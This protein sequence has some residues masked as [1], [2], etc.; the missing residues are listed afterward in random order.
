MDLQERLSLAQAAGPQ[1]SEL[2]SMF[3][4]VITTD[5]ARL[6][7]LRTHESAAVRFATYVN[8]LTNVSVSDLDKEP[9]VRFA[10]IH[11]PTTST[12]V[13]DHIGLNQTS[14]NPIIPET[15]HTHKNASKEF[16]VFRAITDFGR[17]SEDNDD[18]WNY[19]FETIYDEP[20]EVKSSIDLITLE[21]LLYSYILNFIPAPYADN[22]FWDYCYEEV[23]P[24]NFK[25]NLDLFGKLPAIPGSL[26]D[27]CGTIVGAR[28]QA[29][30]LTNDLSLMKSLMWDKEL[31]STGI[32]GLYWQDTRSP[33][34]SVASNSD[35][36]P[37]MLRELFEEESKDEEGLAD[38]Q[39]PVIWRLSCN[40]KSPLDVLEGIVSLIESSSISDEDALL[41]G[42][43]SD[44][45]Y[46]LI[47]NPSV[48]GA[49]RNRVE[50][51][52]IERF[53]DPADYE[54]AED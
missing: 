24:K 47:T 36:T 16:Q 37:E 38:Y 23:E 49:L 50:K 34:S 3:E 27:E 17:I 14:V 11:N 22:D 48:K 42:E 33:R 30:A 25:E 54:I 20:I 35:A 52:L 13:L 18:G 39:H 29:A 2:A 40:P 9:F 53:L 32:G 46:G 5:S 31:V 26:F 21:S 19:F 51:L 28:S 44:F 8:P 12:E 1:Y 43:E 7:E 10:A 45:P 4:A 15:I 6:S 41:V